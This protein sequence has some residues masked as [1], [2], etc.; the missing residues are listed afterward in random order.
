MK[1]L[2]AVL[3]ILVLLAAGA[4]A[5]A[6]YDPGSLLEEFGGLLAE[7]GGEAAEFASETGALAG[8]A[9]SGALDA[10]G[11]WFEENVSGWDEEAQRAWETLKSAA[12][13]GAGQAKEGAAKA[14]AVV[15]QKLEEAGVSLDGYLGQTLKAL[16]EASGAAAVILQEQLDHVGAF[17]EA[18]SAEMTDAVS[19]AW[20]TVRTAAADAGAVTGDA[21]DDALETLEDW[22]SSLDVPGAREAEQALGALG[23]SL[24]DMD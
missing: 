21:L 18:N 6:A 11:A 19:A 1:R 23:W 14:W 20:D 22:V 5:W 10:A 2:L 24:E 17:L 15:M 8:E 13:D 3:T 9:L 16:G 7:F 12:L 4:P